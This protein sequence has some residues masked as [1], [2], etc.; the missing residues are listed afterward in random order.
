MFFRYD[1]RELDLLALHAIGVRS[2]RELEEVIEGYSVGVLEFVGSI[3]RHVYYFIGFT[4]KS[5]AMEVAFYITE[6]VD[7][8]TVDVIIPSVES[9][10]NDFCRHCSST[11]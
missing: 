10:I 11:N 6:E 4:K 9:I 1:H 7:I 8:I 2:P 3:G 5:R